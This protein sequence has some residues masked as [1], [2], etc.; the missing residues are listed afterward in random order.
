MESV[1]NS[2]SKI[3]ENGYKVWILVWQEVISESNACPF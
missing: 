3:A 2:E 1:G